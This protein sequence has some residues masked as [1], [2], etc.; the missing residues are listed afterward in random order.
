MNTLLN[1]G[2]VA[3]WFLALVA[4]GFAAALA[5]CSAL[6]I[7]VDVYKGPLSNEREIQVRQYVALARSAKPVLV[8]LRKELNA[9]GPEQK[10]AA[11]EVKDLLCFYDDPIPT[12]A[13]RSKDCEWG[14]QDTASKVALDELKKELPDATR[15]P[16][17]ALPGSDGNRWIE[18]GR[19]REGIDGLH[20]RW[21]ETLTGFNM[22][23]AAPEVQLAERHL[24]EALLIFAER[25]L[26]VVNNSKLFPGDGR[27]AEERS[28]L[29]TLGNTILVHA[30]DLRR[31]AV[32]KERQEAGFSS[33]LKATADANQERQPVDLV[34]DVER[35][36]Q[37]AV[38]QSKALAV[39]NSKDVKSARAAAA[40][41][42]ADSATKS[43]AQK[44]TAQDKDTWNA[45]PWLAAFRSLVEP[46]Y[47]PPF[48]PPAEALPGALLTEATK[49]KAA[50]T[51]AAVAVK[52]PTAVVTSKA[53]WEALRGWLVNQETE[54]PT[55]NAR[56]QRLR[57]T[58]SY[59][60]NH[61]KALVT[62]PDGKATDVLADMQQLLVDRKASTQAEWEGVVKA[63]ELAASAAVPATVEQTRTDGLLNKA[64]AEAHKDGR[65]TAAEAAQTKVRG[66]MAAA[67]KTA[68]S[69][70]VSTAEGFRGVLLAALATDPDAGK[71]EL[72]AAL[73]AA[74]ATVKSA[75]L[76]TGFALDV[77]DFSSSAG[78]AKALPQ[79]IDV[80][81]NVI[82]LLRNR[83][84]RAL[85][86]GKTAEAGHLQNAIDAA[87][88]QRASMVY[89]RPAADYLKN[90]YSATALQDE[91]ASPNSNLLLGYLKR[92]GL[93]G[94][95][96]QARVQLEK[97]FWQNI[98]RVTVSGGG[99]TNYVLAKDDVGNWYVKAYAS[100]TTQIF[101][102]ARNLFLFN[103]GRKLDVNLLERAD[104]RSR[105]NNMGLSETER[106]K[107]AELLAD[108]GAYTTPAEQDFASRSQQRYAAIYLAEAQR[109]GKDLVVAYRGWVK[110][111]NTAWA[112]VLKDTKDPEK[113]TA[114]TRLDT[115]AT[116]LYDNKLKAAAE[117][118]ADVA[119]A[120]PAGSTTTDRAAR[121][122]LEVVD[123]L[124]AGR[125]YRQQLIKDQ[126]AL[127][128]P[129]LSDP[130]KT[131]LL[132][133]T[134]SLLR[135]TL[136]ALAAKRLRSSTTYSDALTTVGDV[137]AAK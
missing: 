106:T 136:D 34:P 128:L 22:D 64:I 82:A 102:S 27:Q 29:Q 19:S 33:E 119:V 107:S 54:V 5:G 122:A 114:V 11:E 117:A 69:S 35:A 130:Q 7:D 123:A 12:P 60:G 87:Y 93:D 52:G 61:S 95:L 81:D 21:L 24:T 40:K 15:Q 70:G 104:L 134:K 41:A 98:N 137:L 32:H 65:V 62:R 126:E 63:A 115:A 132:G 58:H 118:L 59:L 113:S 76:S 6:Q 68:T 4:A 124:D 71:A 120:E 48:G 90:V 45:N 77:K 56:M 39:A 133:T 112:A 131:Q 103:T 18:Q 55:T 121:V 129:G 49:D 30:N 127:D 100:D 94:N 135:E 43:A 109:H 111:L 66:L 110:E 14:K 67:V 28:V 125:R 8:G 101:Q 44:G 20:D 10:R 108:K 78:K 89:I 92:L 36:L 84:I 57:D 97:V 50:L 79:A 26:Y 72:K 86:E 37:A 80:V 31:Q 47:V 1:T 83:R 46:G 38:D 42:Q 51:A 74:T 23:S 85:A 2:C 116:A 99:A 73:S 16:R 13:N 96:P 17:G 91:N 25:M 3:R 75:T 53:V 88:E 9:G 105:A